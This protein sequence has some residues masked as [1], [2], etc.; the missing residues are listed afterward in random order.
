MSEEGKILAA[1]SGLDAKFDDMQKDV[2]HLTKV[3]VDGN[4]QPGLV[5]KVDRLEVAAQQA[6]DNKKGKWT[7]WAAIV[8]SILTVVG[9]GAIAF[10]IG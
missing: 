4:G 8:G 7:I 2:L 3:V 6:K 5:T 9:S 10:F 1:I